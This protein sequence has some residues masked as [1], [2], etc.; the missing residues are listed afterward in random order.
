MW[1]A[2]VCCYSSSSLLAVY[3][4]HGEESAE[5]IFKALD[6]DEYENISQEEVL[7]ILVLQFQFIVEMEKKS[8]MERWLPSLTLWSMVYSIEIQLITGAWVEHNRKREHEARDLTSM[9]NES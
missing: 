2:R 1:T 7:D 4:S 9:R 3:S 6:D 8:L 5:Y